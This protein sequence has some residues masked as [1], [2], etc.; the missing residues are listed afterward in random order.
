MASTGA[1]FCEQVTLGLGGL[2]LADLLR[3]QAGAETTGTKQ[4]APPQSGKN[5]QPGK[6]VIFVELGGG[7][8]HFETYDPKPSAAGRIPR[9]AGSGRNQSSRRLP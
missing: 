2:T 8:S 3:L 4:D 5:K 7:P 9:P 6:A 1:V